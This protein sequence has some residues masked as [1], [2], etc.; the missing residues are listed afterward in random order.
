MHRQPII[1]LLLAG[2]FIGCAERIP[3]EITSRATFKEDFAA[4]HNAP[5]RFEG[6][7]AL[8]GGT[9]IA[10]QNRE[11][12][13]V[14]TILQFPLDSDYRPQTDH[15]SGGRFRVVS[16][17]FLDPAAYPAGT[18]VTVAGE[19]EGSET[20]PIGTYRYVYPVIQARRIWT[21]APESGGYPRVTFGFG[22]GTVF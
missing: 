18:I 8:L 2:L 15:I 5:G 12:N 9:V 19:I 22:V 7:F 11:N 6:Q 10:V 21:W 16:E 4:L 1:F 17:G 20:R 13:S 14:M 3:K